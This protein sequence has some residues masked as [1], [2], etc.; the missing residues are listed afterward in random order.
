VALIY[1]SKHASCRCFC[2]INALRQTTDE[3][4]KISQSHAAVKQRDGYTS[5]RQQ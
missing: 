3:C 2:T 4:Q 5:A 1:K